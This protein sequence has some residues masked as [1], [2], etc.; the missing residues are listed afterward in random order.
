MNYIDSLILIPIEFRQFKQ[1]PKI[2]LKPS[3]EVATDIFAAKSVSF[4]RSNHVRKTPLR[5]QRQRQVPEPSPFEALYNRN[6][7]QSL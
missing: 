2:K 1:N 6:T 3:K 5:S 4:Q 7:K